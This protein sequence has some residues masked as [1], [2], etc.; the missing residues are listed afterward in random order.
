LPKKGVISDYEKEKDKYFNSLLEKKE[1]KTG[2]KLLHEMKYHE[3][4]SAQDNL[5]NEMSKYIRRNMIEQY[6]ELQ[7]IADRHVELA[8]EYDTRDIA[9]E[10][11]DTLGL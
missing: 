5:V 6:T 8:N 4:I 1:K 7:K 2:P 11:R 9:A 3:I 10:A